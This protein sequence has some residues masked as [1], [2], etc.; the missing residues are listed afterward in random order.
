MCGFSELYTHQFITTLFPSARNHPAREHS[1]RVAPSAVWPRLPAQRS[2]L[3]AGN[4][5]LFLDDHD[6]P[7]QDVEGIHWTMLPEGPV[8]LPPPIIESNGMLS[9]P[10][11]ASQGQTQATKRRSTVSSGASFPDRRRSIL[12]YGQDAGSLNSLKHT[13]SDERSKIQRLLERYGGAG[14][15]KAK[16]GTTAQA[17]TTA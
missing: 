16:K 10:R 3:D 4:S 17:N 13:R 7:N 5:L 6:T 15:V 12:V 11:Y 1:Y 8:Q 2:W 9:L 14:R